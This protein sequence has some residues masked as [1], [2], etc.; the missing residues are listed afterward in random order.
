VMLSDIKLKDDRT[1]LFSPIDNG[2]KLTFTR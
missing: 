2:R 1:L